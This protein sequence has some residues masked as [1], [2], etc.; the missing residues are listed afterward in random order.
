MYNGNGII[1]WASG[2]KYKGFFLDNKRQGYGKL[3]DPNGVLLYN[4]HLEGFLFDSKITFSELMEIHIK[5]LEGSN[6]ISYNNS[7]KLYI[8]N[9]FSS[10]FTD[11][12]LSQDEIN[13]IIDND[14]SI[15]ILGSKIPL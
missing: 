10:N 1:Y 15:F 8:N 5:S 7:E 4:G 14:N 6:D 12:L 13:E 9:D 3:Y 2:Y 11:Q